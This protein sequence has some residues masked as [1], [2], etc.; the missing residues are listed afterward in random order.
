MDPETEQPPQTDDADPLILQVY[1]A[2]D[3]RVTNGV[4]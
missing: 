1:R 2:E 3:L 4:N